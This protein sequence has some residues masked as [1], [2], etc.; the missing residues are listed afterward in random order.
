MTIRKGAT[1][2]N[3]NYVR[4]TRNMFRAM[5]VSVPLPK[6]C[7]KLFP[8]TKFYW[9]YIACTIHVPTVIDWLW[10]GCWVMAKNDFQYVS[11]PPYWIINIL[12]FGHMTVIKFQ[13]CCC[14]P[15]LDDF[16]WTYDDLTIFK[17]VAVCHLEFSNFWLCGTW[18]L[19][20]CCSASLC[21]MS[22]KLENRMLSYDQKRFSIC[23]PSVIFNKKNLI[24]SHM[25]V[26]EFEVLYTKFHQNQMIFHWIWRY[27]NF[28]EGATAHPSSWICEICSLCHMTSMTVVFCFPVLNVTEI[29]QSAVELWPK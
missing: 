6:F 15:N 19:S 22:M 3:P 18:P 29:G 26:I 2:R 24:F 23:L 28:Q 4:K 5:Q 10:I 20:P 1:R 11:C 14:R 13:I 27:N 25:T 7:E 21:K 8:H 17:M 12:I 9:K 16:S